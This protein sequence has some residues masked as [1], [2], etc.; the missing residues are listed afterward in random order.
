MF[1]IGWSSNIFRLVK[2]YGVWIQFGAHDSILHRR[3]VVYDFA[4]LLLRIRVEDDDAETTVIGILGASGED[5]LT[6]VHQVFEIVEMMRGE[7]R[8]F[9]RSSVGEHRRTNGLDAVE[10]VGHRFAPLF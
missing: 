2:R 5:D 8:F 6:L 1:N 10:K 3:I 9:G 7:F 4:R